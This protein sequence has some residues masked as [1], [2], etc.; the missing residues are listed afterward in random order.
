M[1]KNEL[2]IV[3]NKAVL[4]IR[5]RMCET[6]EEMLKSDMFRMVLEHCINQLESRNSPLIGIFENKRITQAGVTNLINTLVLLEKYE[7]HV[8]P[9][10]SQDR[11]PF[12]R[13]NR[14][15]IILW[16]TCTITGGILTDLL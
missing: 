11:F 8:V 3:G 16:S 9:H 13:I 5:E 15:S 6:A 12:S 14:F 7:N 10:I 4:Y 2:K 1:Q